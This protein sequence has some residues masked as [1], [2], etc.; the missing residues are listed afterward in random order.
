MLHGGRQN[1]KKA[2]ASKPLFDGS[3]IWLF[4]VA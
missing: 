3:I 1:T 4:F 2:A